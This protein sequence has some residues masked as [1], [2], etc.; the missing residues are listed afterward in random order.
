MTLM[1]TLRFR[2]V[3]LA[4]VFAFSLSACASAAEPAPASPTVRTLSVAAVG[5]TM[6]GGTAGPELKIYGY[7]YPFVYVGDVLRSADIAFANLEG[8]LTRRGRPQAKQY[9]FR[10]PPEIVAP[11]LA[12]AGIDVVALA[13]NHAMDYGVEGL[14]DTIDALRTA[15]I[16]YAGAGE[17]SAAAR[18]P[19]IVEAAG[20]RVAVLAYSL[21][22][23]EESW[24][25]ATTPGTAFGHAEHV[26]ADVAKARKQADIVLVSFHWGQEGSV[27]LR[28]YQRELGRAA[29]DAGAA[30][31]LG[32]HPHILQGVERYRDGVIFYSLGNFV[33]GSFSKTA[34]RS[35]IAVMTFE[36]GR[37]RE[38]KMH[39]IDVN[40][41]EVVFQPRLLT[42]QAADEVVR[43]L[44]N[45]SLPLGTTIENQNGLAVL[46]LSGNDVT[47]P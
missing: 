5:D 4:G 42:G 43:T 18:R 33:F 11:A 3:V 39:P 31:V 45:L 6:L 26:R 32:H 47:T 24:A 46:K 35:A 36:N 12:R 7:D 44:Q 21:T 40:N 38:L 13:N 2:L 16:R 30:A 10:S 27:E 34:T 19:A 17:N 22:F 23:P 37:L 8:P 28:P 15:G 25:T 29:I 14:V 9:T 1:S 20:H 41:V